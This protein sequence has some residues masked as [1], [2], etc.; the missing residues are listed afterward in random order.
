MSQIDVNALKK[1]SRGRGSQTRAFAVEGEPDLSG[2]PAGDA[3]EYLRR[4]RHEA[5]QLP[6]VVVSKKIDPRRYDPSRT[7]SRWTPPR[8]AAAPP[9]RSPTPAWSARFASGVA[10][11]R[12]A[13]VRRRTAER[14]G[15]TEPN[16]LPRFAGAWRKCF[17]SRRPVL[18]VLLGLDH[19]STCAGLRGASEVLSDTA[20]KRAPGGT[21]SVEPGESS[22][23]VHSGAGGAERRVDAALMWTFALLIRLEKPVD[24]ET[25]ATLRNLYRACAAF[26][27]HEGTSEARIAQVNII[28]C[29]VSRIFGQKV[30]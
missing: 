1:G 3:F 25:C 26:R 5:K 7:I 15:T 10:D 29:I 11:L 27:A 13:F 18:S 14:A 21:S 2:I 12:Q 8:A 22:V 23:K 9:G 28:M 6:A 16:T 30:N 17:Q 24:A 20:P 19:V 4:V